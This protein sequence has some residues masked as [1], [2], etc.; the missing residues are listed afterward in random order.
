M[1]DGIDA[2][3]RL[4]TTSTPWSD[5]HEM[6]H[7]RENKARER[8]SVPSRFMFRWNIDGRCGVVVLWWWLMKMVVVDDV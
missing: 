3:T 8:M 7:F 5:D 6:R 1:D 4:A 2:A